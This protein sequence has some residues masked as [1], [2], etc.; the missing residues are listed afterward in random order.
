MNDLEILFN[1]REPIVRTLYNQLMDRLSNFGT[2]IV[3]PKK[4]SI[5]LKHKTAFAGIHPKK[6]HFV[7]NIVSESPINS[8]RIKKFEQVSKHRFHNELDIKEL[9]D[10]DPELIDWLQTAYDLMS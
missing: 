6:S 8:P 3:E 10:I 4:T 5:H 9:C 7:L 2:I 1:N